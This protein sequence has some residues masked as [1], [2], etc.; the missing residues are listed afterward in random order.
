MIY[1]KR[2]RTLGTDDAP[3]VCVEIHDGKRASYLTADAAKVL[4]ADF[5][6]LAETMAR[7]AGM[8]LESEDKP[9]PTG[10]E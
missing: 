2:A 1:S 9:V 7:A 3:T 5:A 4:A 10:L 6:A 8:Q